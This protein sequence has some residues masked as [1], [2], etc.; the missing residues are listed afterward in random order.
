[1][2]ADYF[3]DHSHNLVYSYAQGPLSFN[4]M[5]DHQCR[6]R[7]D[8]QF[9]DTMNQLIDF[10]SVTELHIASAGVRHLS[11]ASF[12]SATSRRAIVVDGR[13]VMFGLARMYE[14]LRDRGPEQITVFRSFPEALKWLDL[15][16]DYPRKCEPVSSE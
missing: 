2:P 15:P 4:E 13:D 11:E 3:F 5:I 8:P 10:C 14:I 6:L 12:F 9:R 16:P 7:N 1:M